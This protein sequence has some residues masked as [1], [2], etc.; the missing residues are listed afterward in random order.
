MTTDA[1]TRKRKTL[2]QMADYAFNRACKILEKNQ[3]LAKAGVKHYP[4]RDEMAEYAMLLDICDILDAVRDLSPELKQAI[5]D[6]VAENKR[7]NAERSAK[8]QA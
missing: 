3:R 7:L 5:R 4:R 2:K 1:K 6:Q 8:I